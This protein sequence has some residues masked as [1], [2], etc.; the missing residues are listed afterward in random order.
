LCHES[1][2]TRT[3]CGQM[4]NYFIWKGETDSTNKRFYFKNKILYIDGIE[5]EARG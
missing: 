2:T 5:N 1:Q 4:W 3:E